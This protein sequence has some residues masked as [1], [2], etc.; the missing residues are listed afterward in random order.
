VTQKRGG[1]RKEAKLCCGARHSG[2]NNDV[3]AWAGAGVQIGTSCMYSSAH[4]FSQVLMTWM[5][6]AR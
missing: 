3:T 6:S 4:T 2:G 5:L 1:G